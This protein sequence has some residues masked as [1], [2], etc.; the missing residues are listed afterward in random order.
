MWQLHFL[1]NKGKQEQAVD[2]FGCLK[3]VHACFKLTWAVTFA[4]NEIPLVHGGDR[5]SWAILKLEVISEWWLISLSTLTPL[6]LFN[7]LVN[8]LKLSCP[9]RIILMV[10][11]KTS[12]VASPICQEGQSERIFPMFAFSCRFFLFFPDFFPLF[13]DF[14]HFFAVRGDTLP[15]VPP[16]ATPL[17]KTSPKSQLLRIYFYIFRILTIIY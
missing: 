7:N 10:C 3:R 2:P 17:V 14:W 8:V 16:V 9:F 11:V 4:P 13:P 15:P 5:V 1:L 12:S 6:N